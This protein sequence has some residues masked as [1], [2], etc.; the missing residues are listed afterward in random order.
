MIDIGSFLLSLIKTT[1]TFIRHYE[2]ED[3]WKNKQSIE[4]SMRDF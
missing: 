3:F 4:E 1:S 2:S